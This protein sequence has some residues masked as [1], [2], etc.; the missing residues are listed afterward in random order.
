MVIFS[1]EGRLIVALSRQVVSASAEE[2]VRELLAERGASIDWARFLD[3]AVQHR[4]APLISGNLETLRAHRRPV[5]LDRGMGSTLRAFSLFHVERNRA[6]LAAVHEILDLAEAASL[7]VVLRK[8][9]HL[10]QDVYREPGRRPIGDLDLLVPREQ[11]PALVA[12]LEEHGYRQGVQDGAEIRA[13]SRRESLFWRLYGSDMPKLNRFTDNPYL[14]LVDIDINVALVL[15][16]R[17]GEVPVSEVM[18][19]AV[20]REIAGRKQHFL[21][22]VDC[23]LDLCLNVYKNSTALRFMNLGKHRRLLKYVDIVECL[24]AYGADFSWPTFLDRARE[25]DVLLAMYYAL[26]HAELL[27]PGTVPP[28]VLSRCREGCPDPQ[29][30][31]DRYGQWDGPEPLRWTEPFGVRFFSRESDRAIPP[32][33]S[34]V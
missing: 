18:E 32:S 17:S 10:V 21:S 27:Y 29:L 24:S 9:A 23:V 34:L 28:E 5:K 25:Y 20:T 4:V 31:L 16:G 6:A 19:R 8:G 12:L 2:S 33:R 14:P 26:A 15:P 11:A 3:Q 22:P 30:F 7:H 13:L 1:D